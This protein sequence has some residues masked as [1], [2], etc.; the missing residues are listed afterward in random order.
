MSN[1]RWK[2]LTIIAVTVIFGAVGVYPIVAARYGI[3]GPRILTDRILKLEDGHP[4]G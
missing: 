2:L 3:A 4:A 1:L